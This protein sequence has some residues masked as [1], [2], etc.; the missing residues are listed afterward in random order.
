M[1]F[2]CE[3]C[4]QCSTSHSFEKLIQYTDKNVFYTCPSIATNNEITGIINHLDGV[5][6]ELNQEW[7]WIIDFKKFAIKHFWSTED[8]YKLIQFITLNHISTLH[9]ILVINL[10]DHLKSIY[11]VL[12][13]M[14]N[15]NFK[16]KINFLGKTDLNTLSI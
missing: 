2:K 14:I 15:K 7:I 8:S 9:K 5:L 11:T 12:K 4:E 13:P 6:K 3:L 1:S 10:K 16:S